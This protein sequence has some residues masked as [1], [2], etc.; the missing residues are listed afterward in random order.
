MKKIFF[1]ADPHFGHQNI[2]TYENRPYDSV[3]AMD[4]DLIKRWN[5]VVK[6]QDEVFVLGDFSFYGKEKTAEIVEQLNGKKT[7]IMGN[8]DSRSPKYYYECGFETVSKY[9][10][11]LEEFWM[12][13]HEP[14]YINTNMPYANI[15]GHVHS[16][17]VYANHS[18][19]SFCACVE[20]IDY[21][22]IEFDKIKEKVI[23]DSTEK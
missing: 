15:F 2:I 3:E 20:R 19:Q 7:L 16:N 8:H 18:T 11:I 17:K 21:T 5:Q 9:P 10:I 1:I 22:P 4:H 12:L 23:N 13:S 6:A 14:M